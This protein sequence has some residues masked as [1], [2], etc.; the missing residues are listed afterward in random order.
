MTS[1]PAEASQHE[2]TAA[3]AAN[4]SARAALLWHFE[5]K[6]RGITGITPPE[7]DRNGDFIGYFMM[8]FWRQKTYLGVQLRWI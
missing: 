1:P 4:A 6:V 5:R 8:M 3:A 7:M 2:A